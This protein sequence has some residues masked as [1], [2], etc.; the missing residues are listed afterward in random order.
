[1][2]DASA[3]PAPA[4]R[5]GSVEDI[6]RRYAAAFRPR[7]WIYWCDLLASAALG[8]ALFAL[9]LTLPA[10]SLLHVVTVVTATLALLRGALFIHELAHLRSGSVPG[11]EIAWH[12]L[13]GV[14]LC[15]PSLMYVGSH[16]DHHRR[17]AFGTAEDP[18][19]APIARWN[20]LRIVWFV[21]VV[22]FVPVL[23]VIRWGVLGPVTRLFPLAG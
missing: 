17:T 4:G 16:T 22:A 5:P 6:R 23:L 18:E 13:V 15:I 21:V 10:F 14:P 19:Y 12:A 8:W 20:P 2:G 11:F 9:S 3:T 7:P 1:M